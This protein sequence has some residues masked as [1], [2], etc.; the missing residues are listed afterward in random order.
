MQNEMKYSEC[1]LIIC[2]EHDN[3]SLG[4]QCDMKV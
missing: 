2:D 3:G 1:G 4:T